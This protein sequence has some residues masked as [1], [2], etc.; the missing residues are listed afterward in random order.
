MPIFINSEQQRNYDR[1]D[2]HLLMGSCQLEKQR[3][4]NKNMKLIV[5]HETSIFKYILVFCSMT[6]RNAVKSKL[7]TELDAELYRESSK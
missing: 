6:Y 5:N 2:G 3:T 7:F 4:K 1:T